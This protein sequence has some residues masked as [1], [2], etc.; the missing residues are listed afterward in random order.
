[1]LSGGTCLG[2][3]ISGSDIK[4]VELRGSRNKYEVVQ[5][6]R[7]K[8]GDNIAAT[9]A[10]FIAET[11]TRCSKI[12]LSLPTNSCS[13]KFAALPKT[14]PAET[15]KMAHYEAETQI[16]LPL[17][18]M[19]WGYSS[20]KPTRGQEQNHIVIAAVRRTIADELASLLEEHNLSVSALLVNCLAEVHGLQAALKTAEEPVLLIDLGDE[21]TDITTVQEGSVSACHCV[22]L[23]TDALAQAVADD[24]GIDVSEARQRIHDHYVLQDHVRSGERLE[25]EHWFDSLAVE[26]RRSALGSVSGS[27]TSAAS[28]AFLVGEGAAIPGIAEVVSEKSNLVTE[29]VNPWN[30]MR[31]GKVALHNERDI[32]AVFA[33]ATGL[34]MIGLGHGG[35]INLMPTDRAEKMTKERKGIAV[36]ASL[37]IAA[38]LLVFVLLAGDVSIDA[39]SA[40]L[41]SLR[42]QVRAARRNPVSIQPG[43]KTTT[44][45]MNK[46]IKAAHNGDNSPLEILVQLSQGLPSSCSLSEIQFESGK[47]VV[48]RGTALSNSA[49]A[50]L[51]YMLSNNPAFKSVALDYSNIGRGRNKSTYDFQ[52]RCVVPENAT[53]TE[54]SKNKNTKGRMVVR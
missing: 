16:P 31:L 46:V 9:L 26:I 36:A 34:A 39:Q 6:A 11:H 50:D 45:T 51:V 7:L 43:L 15:A 30:G 28:R 12:V 22:H 27:D 52:L 24:L 38:M 17:A 41:Q 44:L 3:D 1:M 35:A 54:L 49:I 5:A 47:S 20:E 19:I 2:V 25:V 10:S 4:A 33:G 40:E 37:G 48:L 23:G 29:T 21:W 53:L 42:S 13:V 32:P 8:V 18:D 14:K